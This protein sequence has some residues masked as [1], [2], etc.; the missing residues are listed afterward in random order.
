MTIEEV[1][2]ALNADDFNISIL[3][4]EPL[5]QYPAI[6]ELCRL[7]KERTDKTIWMW[8]GYEMAQVKSL[9]NELIKY[10][11][12]IVDGVFKENL[13]DTTLPFRGS[14]NQRIYEIVH[15]P[16]IRI[17]DISNRFD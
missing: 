3:G 14:K 8:T 17:T 4:G 12:V 11:D 10:V 2:A 7:I 9:F 13:R 15:N 16:E 5:V 1:Y 6:L